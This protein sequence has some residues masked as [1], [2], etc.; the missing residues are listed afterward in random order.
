MISEEELI[1]F[2][3]EGD[4]DQG[5]REPTVTFRFLGMKRYLLHFVKE[6]LH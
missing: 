4:D 1:E 5:R 6:I 3:A 2:S